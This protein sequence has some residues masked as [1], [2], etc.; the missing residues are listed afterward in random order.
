MTERFQPILAALRSPSLV[1]EAN[2]IQEMLNYSNF[3]LK[4]LDVS[5]PKATFNASK[6][7][8]PVI[9]SYLTSSY[10]EL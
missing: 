6:M 7:M 10:L 1:Q 5:V 9:T 3:I 4:A 8:V 2:L